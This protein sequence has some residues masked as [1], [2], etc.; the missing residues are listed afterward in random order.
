[1][2]YGALV[3]R[4]GLR[5]CMSDAGCPLNISRLTIRVSGKGDWPDINAALKRWE[6]AG[7]LRIIKAPEHA[8]DSDIC[9][10]LLAPILEDESITGA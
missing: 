8:E 7:Y 10:E 9:I 3:L 1:M 6:A 5:R 2:G 4:N